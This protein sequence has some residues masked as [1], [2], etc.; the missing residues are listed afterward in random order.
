MPGSLRLCRAFSMVASLNATIQSGLTT[1]WTW[2]MSITCPPSECEACGGLRGG[3]SCV[4]LTCDVR[5]ERDARSAHES[6]DVHEGDKRFRGLLTEEKQTG[7]E[8]TGMLPPPRHDG[9]A[10][11]ASHVEHRPEQHNA[12]AE[13]GADHHVR[14]IVNP[15][16]HAGNEDG[17]HNPTERENADQAVDQK[18]RGRKPD[19]K[20]GRV[21]RK[22]TPAE[23]VLALDP[24]GRL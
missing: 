22:R 18:Q 19:E 17:E 9:T 6:H 24:I 4:I 13:H 14:R 3:G 10:H 23:Q 8:N 5:D 16:I 11:R 7:V 12:G 15:E 1:M 2:T 20:S 21:A